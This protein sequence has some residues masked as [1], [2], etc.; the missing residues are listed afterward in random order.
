[1]AHTKAKGSARINKDSISKRLGV[2]RNDSQP[3]KSGMIIIRQKGTKY[4]NGPGV[5]RGKDFTLFAV[6]DGFVHFYN[7]AGKKYVSVKTT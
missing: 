2:K 6:T 1:M 4:H 3:V 7:R 5:S